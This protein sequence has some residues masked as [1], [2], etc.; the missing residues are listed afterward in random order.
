ML[1]TQGDILYVPRGMVHL[2]LTDGTGG[3][4]SEPGCEG[5]PS[6]NGAS[7]HI[8]IAIA[9]DA[10]AL[11]WAADLISFPGIERHNL[12]AGKL[13]EAFEAVAERS[14]HA[15]RS[16]GRLPDGRSTRGIWVREATSLLHEVVEELMANTSFADEVQ[17]RMLYIRDVGR[18]QSWSLLP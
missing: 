18:D 5:S 14:P 15:R 8:T 2:T 9:L 3:A 6:L 4:G 13:T 12:V 10:F 1:L 17:A 16:I 7:L 11:G